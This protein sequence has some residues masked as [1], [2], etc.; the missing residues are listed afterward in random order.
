MTEIPQLAELQ[1]LIE[2]G[3]PQLEARTVCE[4]QAGRR[5]FP[6]H[7]LTLG[8]PSPEVPA[9]GFFGGVHG[10]ER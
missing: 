9:V 4:V 8:N 1:S 2:E 5:R 10:L 7:A 6:I 3:H